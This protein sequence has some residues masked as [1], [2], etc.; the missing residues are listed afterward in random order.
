MK[1]QTQY[2]VTRSLVR[3][4]RTRKGQRGF[5]MEWISSSPPPWS[6]SLWSSVDPSA[7]CSV[8]QQM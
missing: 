1:E 3:E 2:S 8:P 6:V 7:T 5:A 4:R